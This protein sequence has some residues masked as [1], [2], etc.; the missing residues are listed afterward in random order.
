[1]G[2]YMNVPEGMTFQGMWAM[3]L[4]AE[5]NY[6]TSQNF[7]LLA[8]YRMRAWRL[9]R[10]LSSAGFIASFD[11]MPAISRGIYWN[12]RNSRRAYCLT[13][14]GYEFL[15]KHDSLRAASYFKPSRYR[16]ITLNHTAAC[17]QT[18]IRFQGH[19]A[20][21]DYQPDRILMRSNPQLH[22]SRRKA[23]NFPDAMFVYVSLKEN[24]R[25]HCGAVEVELSRKTSARTEEKLRAYMNRDD[26]SVVVWVCGSEYI[27]EDIKRATARFPHMPHPARGLFRFVLYSDLLKHRLYDT[28]ATDYLGQP[29]RAVFDWD[30]DKE[31]AANEQATV[32]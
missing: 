32:G 29:C 15:R 18:R 2:G 5:H 22:W 20:V 7:E 23:I 13:K 14:R 30:H 28:P 6:I 16:I 11:T 9:V 4:M 3:K 31:A 1:M 10:S 24:Y 8:W 26:L 25:R 27:R 17:V 21:Q 19:S 12:S